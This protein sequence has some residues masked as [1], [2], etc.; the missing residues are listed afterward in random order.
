[1]KRFGGY[2]GGAAP[3]LPSP[4]PAVV[5]CWQALALLH[6]KAGLIHRDIKP[7]NIQAS[8]NPSGGKCSFAS[9]P[10]MVMRHFRL[11]GYPHIEMRL[12]LVDFE[13][14]Y[15]L[16][17]VIEDHRCGTDGYLAPEYIE[18]TASFGDPRSIKNLKVRQ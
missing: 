6:E 12:K 1:M 3:H 11:L 4:N 7:A 10:H 5:Y 13:F 14:A 2:C 16:G 8:F 18:A 17:D 9:T 15:R